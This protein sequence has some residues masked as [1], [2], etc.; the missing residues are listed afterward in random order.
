M[1]AQVTGWGFTVEYKNPSTVLKELR[2]PIIN[3]KECVKQL[4]EDYQRFLTHDKL[5]AG[6][7]D[8]G[9]VFGDVEKRK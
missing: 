3:T 2:V 1:I 5:C 4:A 6:F 9:K 8:Q 7:L